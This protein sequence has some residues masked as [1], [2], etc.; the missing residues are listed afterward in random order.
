LSGSSGKSAGDHNCPTSEVAATTRPADK[1]NDA[2]RAR[3]P[4][5][6]DA[7]RRPRG[8]PQMV[9]AVAP[10]FPDH[11][12]GPPTGPHRDPP[13][14]PS[15]GQ[16]TAT[17]EDLLLLAEPV[18]PWILHLPGAYSPT[19]HRAAEKWH[20]DLGP[21][22]RGTFVGGQSGPRPCSVKRVVEPGSK[23]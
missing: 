15:I 10:G 21:S 20:P 3:S 6:G 9:R 1:A 7:V 13:S 14:P 19:S 2:S 22:R 16:R 17:A 8:Q 12:A 23:G 11:L 5:S 18:E 4:G